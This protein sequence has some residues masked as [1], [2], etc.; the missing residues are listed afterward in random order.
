MQVQ[1]QRKL[2]LFVIVTVVLEATQHFCSLCEREISILHI[3][4]NLVQTVDMSSDQ[5]ISGNS[6]SIEL[7][8]N[9]FKWFKPFATLKN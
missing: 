1:T 7:G 3:R 6:Q 4:W 5:T 9:P 8:E 2:Y